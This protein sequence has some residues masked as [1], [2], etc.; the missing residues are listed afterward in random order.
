[1]LAFIVSDN[2]AAADKLRRILVNL[3]VECG[4]ANIITTDRALDMT[5][6]L[7]D[8]AELVFVILS[9][10]LDRALLLISSLRKSSRSKLIA[11]GSAR[12]PQQI[13]RVVQA[14]SDGYVDEAG[15]LD[16]QVKST[17]ECV[18]CDIRDE[19]T[20]GQ[21][22]TIMASNGGTGRS[23]VCANLAFQLAGE[24]SCCLA[25][26]DLRRGDLASM[27]NAKPRHTIVDL[28]ANTQCLDEQMFQE[29]L[30]DCGHGVHLLAAPQTLDDVQQVTTEG[31][32][33]V[34]QLARAAF[35]FVIV[36]LEDFFHREQFR[37]LQLSDTILFT[38]HME[39]NGLRNARRTLEY[40]RQA[41]IDEQRVQL[42][43]N[44]SGRPKELSV[45]QAEDALRMKIT[46]FIPDDPKAQ[47]HALNSG[48]PA[49][50]DNPRSRL[51]KAIKQLT[52]V[53]SRKL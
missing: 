32:E 42:V 12:D 16:S 28:C 11:V 51:S 48:V 39:F 45:A 49:V 21:V 33:R 38:F 14:G 9:A 53:R 4:V 24:G 15:D 26:L 43:A 40:L 47:N 6:R 20:T 52:T 3:R 18:K 29:A 10:E 2:Q 22:I 8:A 31:V 41:G 13:L 30:Y 37:V 19:G 50:I 7:T 1:M 44:Q 17:L 5:A 35:D 34:I 46:H 36:D 25:D 27:V 23:T